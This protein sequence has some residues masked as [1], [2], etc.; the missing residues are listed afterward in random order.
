ML[1]SVGFLLLR[2]KRIPFVA[3]PIQRFFS[4]SDKSWLAVAGNTLIDW[5]SPIPERIPNPNTN[6]YPNSSRNEE[7][8]FSQDDFSTI[9]NLFT[10]S[11][12]SPGPDLEAALDRAGIQPSSTLLQAIFDHFD[13]SPK[14]LHSLFLWAEKQTGCKLSTPLFNSMINVLAKSR[15][16]DSAWNLLL[17]QMDSDQEVSLVS[18]DTF[19]IMIRRYAR[20]GMPQPAIRTFEFARN[21]KSI[22]DFDS[23]MSLFEMLLDSLCKEGS[24]RAASEYFLQKKKIDPCWVP[25]IRVYNIM[26]NG[27]FR[28]RKLKQAERF[29][30]GMKKE[31]VRPSVVTYGTLVE[32]YCRMRRIEKALEL[33]DDMTNEGIKPNA[34][35]YN[36]II[37]ALA[38]A[39]RFKEALGMMER[40]H[41]MEI[42]PTN[43]TYNSLVKGFCKAGDV[44]GASKILKMMISRGFVPSSITYS[45]FFK[46]FSR[47]GKIEEGMNLYTKMIESGHTP[48]RL[49]YHL[50]V[51]ML[52][53]EERLD[54]AVQVS[55]EMRCKGYDMDLATST[56]MVHLLCKMHRLDDAFTE[57]EDMI[58]RGIVPQYLTFQRMHSELKSRG[59]TEMARDLCNLMSSVPHS[60][61]LPNTYI[62]DVDDARMR[63]KSIMQKAKTFSDMLKNCEDPR[64]LVK[65]RSSSETT[66]SSA[67]CLIE[68]IKKK[69]NET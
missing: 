51:K 39:G 31:N 22:L 30:A 24:V 43:S 35:V 20:A 18:I 49:T 23:E 59:M 60:T 19:A 56:M 46:Y 11:T 41:V 40:F 37:D 27:W 64:E 7:S 66:V 13:S 25:S 8:K 58:R 12:I 6:S 52:C 10:D 9:A 4:S 54:L 32:G 21:L 53:E 45:Y 63:R 67:N 38:E 55:K 48:D 69:T 62:E 36:P 3:F 26:L 33:V 5:P 50:L 44:A 28:S 68:S 14:L 34:I 65:H 42:G 57:F 15:E 16:F 47:C 17:D 61:K 1:L 29:W 2:P